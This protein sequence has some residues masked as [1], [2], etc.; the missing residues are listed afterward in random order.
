[1]SHQEHNE[2]K[3]P[4]ERTITFAEA[5]FAPKI[6]ETGLVPNEQGPPSIGGNVGDIFDGGNYPRH[7]NNSMKMHSYKS[8]SDQLQEQRKHE[9]EQRRKAAEHQDR[10]ASV[11]G[12]SYAM[13]G[14]QGYGA[15]ETIPES[16]IPGQPY[17]G[18]Y[19][20]GQYGHVN[21]VVTSQHQYAPGHY[22]PGHPG[23]VAPGNYARAELQSSSY[24]SPAPNNFPYHY[25]DPNHMMPPTSGEHQG[26]YV[27]EHAPNAQIV[28]GGPQPLYWT[29]TID[30]FH[31]S[32]VPDQM[33]AD[34]DGNDSGKNVPGLRMDDTRLPYPY[35]VDGAG[36]NLYP[37]S[38][39]YPPVQ[40]PDSASDVLIFNQG[41]NSDELEAQIY[42]Q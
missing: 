2:E 25:Y 19:H 39:G 41:L 31:A 32:L 14:R 24:V 30:I 35:H 34:Y 27:Q 6:E 23:L 7:L 12:S 17:S 22:T 28:S 21:H 4:K 15:A 37:S 3:N 40:H 1:M 9:E 8:Y 42:Q 29:G 38:T 20:G 26:L 16:T 5:N 13:D 33:Y 11:A 10:T 18:S 36:N